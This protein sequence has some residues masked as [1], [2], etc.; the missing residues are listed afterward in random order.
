MYIHMSLQK[1][2]FNTKATGSILIPITLT[3]SLAQYIVMISF[4]GQIGLSSP[5]SIIFKEKLL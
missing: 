2:N 5:G 1:L 4:K 3:L